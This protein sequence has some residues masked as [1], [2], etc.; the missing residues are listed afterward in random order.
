MKHKIAFGLYFLTA[1]VLLGFG[2]RYF[3]ATQLMPYHAETL[4]VARD[5]LSDAYQLVFLTLYRATGAGMLVIGTTLLVLLIVPYRQGQPWARWA[6]TG[7]GLMY[8]ILSAYL[9]LVYQADTA[10]SVPWQGPVVSI[11]VLVIA[12]FLSAGRVSHAEEA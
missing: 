6:L 2:G 10:A 11:V 9:T 3:F 5:G 4:G 12:H 1:L 8:G 7:V